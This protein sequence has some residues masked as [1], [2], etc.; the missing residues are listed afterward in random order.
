MRRYRAA[1]AAS[2]LAENEPAEASHLDVLAG[3]GDRIL[4]DGLDR[5]LVVP[6]VR[7]LEQA[8]LRI[9]LVELAGH[10]LVDH[11]RRLALALHLR[12][13]DLPLLLDSLRRNVLA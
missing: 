8:D 6:D 3:L 12:A 1:M 9:E 2:V 10:D 7:L 11:L 5:A 4:D 13:E